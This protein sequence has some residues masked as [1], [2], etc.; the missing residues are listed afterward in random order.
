MSTEA[1]IVAVQLAG[2]ACVHAPWF[3]I[4][5]ERD[6]QVLNSHKRKG[7]LQRR[8]PSARSYSA[9]RSAR[10]ALR[11]P[12]AM[13]F[14]KR[15]LRLRRQRVVGIMS[16]PH[17]GN[18]VGVVGG[19]RQDAVP[20]GGPGATHSRA[21]RRARGRMDL[22]ALNA[23]LGWRRRASDETVR[24]GLGVF[25]SPPGVAASQVPI[26]AHARK[27]VGEYLLDTMHIRLRSKRQDPPAS[28]L[29]GNPTRSA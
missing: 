6:R 20:Q 1:G 24:P 28:T 9:L 5:R 11:L 13:E 10:T 8:W 21:H 2:P 27:P 14:R 15:V 12:K 25:F 16:R 29:G 18:R 22:A 3:G 19:G 17:A 23:K 4:G 7:E 26:R